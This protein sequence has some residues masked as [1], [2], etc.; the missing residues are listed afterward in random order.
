VTST[1]EP[2]APDDVDDQQHTDGNG[3]AGVPADLPAIYL[4]SDAEA[5]RALTTAV[6][7]G[8]LPDVYVSGGQLVHL[9]R[10]S[11]HTSSD[12]ADQPL[13]T[14]AEPLSV[15]SLAFLLAHHTYCYRVRKEEKTEA[16]PSKTTL[17]AVLSHRYWP[18]VRPLLGIV[19]S[20]VLRPDGTLLQTTGY[21]PATGLYYA[22]KIS[23]PPIPAEPTAEQVAEAK[24]FILGQLLRDFPFVD[25]ADKANHVGLL[26][27]PILRPY[28]KCLTPFGL[29]SATTQS[30]GKTLLAE[31]LGYLYGSKTLVWRKG[32]PMTLSTGGGDRP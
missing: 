1:V 10:V 29:I 24:G 8:A 28:L 7:G 17:A 22:P 31:I 9:S 18:G 11:G 12:S 5:I 20:P 19:G 15:S 23:V 27:A 14:A 13:P 6:A 3:D 2:P 25:T 32:F 26:L 30:S 16:S 21:D 4:G